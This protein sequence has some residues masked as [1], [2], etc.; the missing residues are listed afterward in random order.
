MGFDP[1]LKNVGKILILQVFLQRV[2][3]G[4]LASQQHPIKSRS[5]EDYLLGIA[6]AYLSMGAPDPRLGAGHKIDFR[7]T[8]MLKAYSKKEPPPNRVEP[9][10]VPVIRRICMVT[11]ASSDTIS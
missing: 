7:I 9:V 1:L 6:Q 10:T 5:A 4:N 11:Y 2:R 3:S 8:H